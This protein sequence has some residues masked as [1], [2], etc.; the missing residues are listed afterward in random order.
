MA[1]GP[2]TAEVLSSVGL[3]SH[4]SYRVSVRCPQKS[5]LWADVSVLMAN[6]WAHLTTSLRD[7]ER[8]CA[9]T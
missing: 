2:M 4:T 1:A 8:E 9:L 6:S 5:A 7:V 3:D